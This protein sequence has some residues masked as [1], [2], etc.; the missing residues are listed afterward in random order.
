MAC[1]GGQ[2]CYILKT[3]GLHEGE[4][5]AYLRYLQRS[6]ETV[7]IMH[8]HMN[9]FANMAYLRPVGR[10]QLIR[11][12]PLEVLVADRP[13][14]VWAAA[15]TIRQQFIEAITQHDVFMG[16]CVSCALY[17][18][19]F[20]DACMAPLCTHCDGDERLEEAPHVCALCITA[21]NR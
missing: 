16:V 21:N 10:P 18:G 4:I 11:I 19:C 7:R 13:L 20:C 14:W 5:N 15:W 9:A 8:K 6:T 12:Q 2:L 3:V 1:G 17:T